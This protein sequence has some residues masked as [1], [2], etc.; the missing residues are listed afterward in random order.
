M[1]RWVNLLNCRTM[2]IPFSYLGLPINVNPKVET[3]WRPVIDK[4]KREGIYLKSQ[5][6]II[7]WG[8]FV[9]SIW[10]CLLYLSF[11]FF[12]QNA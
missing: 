12:F 4:L 3:T 6:V 7:V 11:T 10:Y 9:S 8:E 5:K 1:K 2:E